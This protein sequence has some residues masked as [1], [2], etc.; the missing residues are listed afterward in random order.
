MSEDEKSGYILDEAKVPPSYRMTWAETTTITGLECKGC[1]HT[2]RNN[3]DQPVSCPDCGAGLIWED[4]VIS[5]GEVTSDKSV[6]SLFQ[7]ED[8]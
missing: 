7:G 2:W 1:G 8:E 6:E 3:V 5:D 4:D